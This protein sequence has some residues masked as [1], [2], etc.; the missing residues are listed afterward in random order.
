MTAR[1]AAETADG[2]L[3]CRAYD[4]AR[5]DPLRRMFYNVTTTGLS[6]ALAL[7]IGAVELLQMLRR[8]LHLRGSFFDFIGGLDFGI[9][10]YAIVAVF[11]VTW[12][13][14]AALWKSGRIE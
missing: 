13:I 6:V 10:G 4:W 14:S 9:V 5:A 2:V 12:A 1:G 8:A 11:L 3:M 7:A